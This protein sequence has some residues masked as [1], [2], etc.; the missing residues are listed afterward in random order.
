M[1]K[2]NLL[3]LTQNDKG[4][5]IQK[6]NECIIYRLVQKMIPNMLIISLIIFSIYSQ[7][8]TSEYNITYSVILNFLHCPM[9]KIRLFNLFTNSYWR[10]YNRAARNPSIFHRL[11]ILDNVHIIFLSVII[12]LLPSSVKCLTT[13]FVL[14]FQRLPTC[15]NWNTSF[16]NLNNG[17]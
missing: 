1:T 14:H 2:E 6:G 9:F 16:F 4:S 15:L 8:E 3:E 11:P 7:P 13:I 17:P 5:W 12:R 10:F